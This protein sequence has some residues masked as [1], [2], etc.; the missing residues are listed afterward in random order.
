MRIPS[1]IPQSIICNVI[2][3][4]VSVNRQLLK[5]FVVVEATYTLYLSALSVNCVAVGGT[6]Y[7]AIYCHAE[8]FHTGVVGPTGDVTFDQ[9]APLSVL[10]CQI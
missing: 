5:R 6:V 2:T 4:A 3:L 7:V 9:V 1:G 10:R 8:P